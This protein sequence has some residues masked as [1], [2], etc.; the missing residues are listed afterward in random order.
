M[1]ILHLPENYKTI[2][3]QDYKKTLDYIHSH[4]SSKIDYGI[5]LGSGLSELPKTILSKST[6]PAIDAGTRNP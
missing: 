5:I 2:D 6:A 4:T 1:N 3:I